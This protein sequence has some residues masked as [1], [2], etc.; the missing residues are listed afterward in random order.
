MQD[1]GKRHFAFHILIAQCT[2]K[3]KIDVVNHTFLRHTS[4]IMSSHAATTGK[5]QGN[6]NDETLQT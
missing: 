5:K 2:M 6:D 3:K 4:N 1:V